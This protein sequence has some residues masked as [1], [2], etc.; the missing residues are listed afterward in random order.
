M[1]QNEVSFWI[2]IKET[3]AKVIDDIGKRFVIT[4]GDI[5]NAVLSIG[6]KLKDLGQFFFNLSLD[7]SKV[8][9]VRKAFTNLA[10][11]Q[12]QDADAI[13]S[14]MKEMSKGTITE[15]QLM[16]QANQAMALG[17]P[18]EKFDEML[19]I[20]QSA[21]KATGQSMEFMLNSIVTGLGRGSKLMLDNLG[22]LVDIDAANKRYADTIGKTVK[23]LSDYEKKQA[24][25]NEALRIGSKN[26]DAM[27]TST[28]SLS[29]QWEQTKVKVE[30]LGIKIGSML[31]PT[32]TK[33]LEVTNLL[34]DRFSTPWNLFPENDQARLEIA[35]AQLKQIEEQ[36]AKLKFDPNPGYTESLKQQ[37]ATLQEKVNQ[38]YFAD[39][40][41]EELKNKKLARQQVI[42]ENK[43]NIHQQEAEA[44]AAKQS[45]EDIREAER[46]AKQ[47]ADMQHRLDMQEIEWTLKYDAQVAAQLREYESILM[48][49]TNKEKLLAAARNKENLL[50]KAEDD[51]KKKDMDAI[52]Q[53]EA[54]LQNKKVQRATQTMSDLARMQDSKS[55]ELVAIGRAAATAQI[56]MDTARAVMGAWSWAMSIPFAGPAIAA[57]LSA[58]IIAYGAEQISR[59]H[60]AQMAEGGIVRAQPGG[61]LAT[62]GEGGRDEAVI[63][64]DEAGGTL[65]TNITIVVNGGLLGDES[66][67]R[68]FA[69]ALDRE[70]L[71]L[72]R[73][74]QSLAFDESVI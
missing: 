8:E 47:E 74:N 62:I 69:V 3:G 64:L 66:S 1:A 29:Q 17:L 60:S 16:Q 73:A 71:K 4:A 37:I 41:D 52:D 63:P 43:K 45:E 36:I 14:K 53:Y 33:L 6:D 2:K 55:K 27:G 48:H 23:E 31:I 7:A 50:R 24:F 9:E 40:V 38:E 19:K 25:I 49:E 65:G 12:G 26:A 57:A 32:F 11:S 10:A 51:K 67:A 42:L 13:L 56:T 22:I 61:M 70:F 44:E 15:L 39:E 34:F 46:K 5:A 35:K 54:F 30:E 59:V 21:A 18:V 20:A 72:R 58:A 68:E 28:L